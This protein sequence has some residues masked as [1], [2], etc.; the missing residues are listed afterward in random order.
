MAAAFFERLADPSRA[1]CVSAGTRPAASVHPEVVTAML[2][3]GID[4]SAAHPALLTPELA[5]GASLL[6]T[7][8]CGEECPVVPGAER[9]DWPLAD[10]KFLDLAEV[11]A[12]RAEAEA[13]VRDLLD[14][15]GWVRQDG[16]GTKLALP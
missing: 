13:R 12:V 14:R 5:A 1:A 3:V 10:P 16:A 4:L 15:R 2:E 11:R 6:V 7:M 8:G 9:E